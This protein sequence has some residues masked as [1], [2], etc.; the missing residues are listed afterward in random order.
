MIKTI[1]LHLASD[2]RLPA[3][4]QATFGLA[5]EHGAAVLG[6]APIS[7]PMA[8]AYGEVPI[9]AELIE[10]QRRQAQARA[11]AAGREFRAAGERAKLSVDWLAEEND[12]AEALAG[13]AACADLLVLSQEAPGDA[14][15]IADELALRS[16]APVLFIP[17]AGSH[18]TIGRKALVAWNGAREAA[19]A[20]R[21]A[22]PLLARAEQVTLVAADVPAGRRP[23]LDGARAYLERHGVAAQ[24]RN[25]P[26]ADV[27]A[28]DVLLNAIADEGADLLV[29]GAY[30]HSRLRELVLGGVTRHVLRHMTAPVLMSH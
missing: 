6:V 30:G 20:M 9:S 18:E 23:G 19:R 28:G 17:Y 16:A 21:D 25:I 3:R 2:A 13:Y 29:M 27:D 15:N 8:A 26:G 5:A 11:E 10:E 24:A 14:L 1:V 22:L 12:P 4:Q 7:P